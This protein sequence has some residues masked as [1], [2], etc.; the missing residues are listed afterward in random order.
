MNTYLLTHTNKVQEQTIMKEILKTNGYQ[1]SII[2]H[3]HIN[4]THKNLAQ[5]IQ[6]EKE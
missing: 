6:K 4:K 3:K 5:E 1:Q 2:N